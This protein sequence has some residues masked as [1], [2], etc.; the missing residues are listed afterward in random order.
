MALKDLLKK[1]DKISNGDT[2]ASARTL[3]PSVPEFQFLRTT[4]STQETIEPPTFP[5]DPPTRYD[6]PLLSPDPQSRFGMF[7][8]KSSA[9]NTQGGGGGGWQTSRPEVENESGNSNGNGNNNGTGSGKGK[10]AERL[11]FGRTRSASSINVPDNLP[12]VGGDGVARTEE[13][14]ASWERRATVLVTEGLAHGAGGVNS[15]GTPGFENADFGSVR[16]GSSATG[17]QGIAITP[18]NEQDIQEA[19]RLHEKGNLEASTALFGRLAEPNGANNALAQVLYGLALRH[20]WGIE[21]DPSQAVHYL[22]MAA[23]NSASIESL[24]LK[25]G[26]KKGGAAKG[27]LVLAMYE[28]ANCFRNGW[29]VKRD[30]AAA[31]MYYETAANLGDTDA[32]NEVAWCYTEGFG[33]KK[34]KFKAAQFL[35]LAETKGNKTLGNTWIWKDK[36]NP[37]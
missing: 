4:T 19:I 16:P 13:E 36:Y 18:E 33:C 35:R 25:A 3:S 22:S 5:G 31:K 24:A 32:M 14:E 30:P 28:L 15:P 27:E 21:P 2:T 37:K 23:S 9:G 7:R 34:D 11:H 29:G 6:K 8:S 17:G 1:K 20:A 10:L 12:D 26:L